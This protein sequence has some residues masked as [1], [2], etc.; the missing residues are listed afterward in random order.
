MKAY[1][2]AILLAI[3]SSYSPVAMQLCRAGIGMTLPQSGE[4]KESCGAP[5][6]SDLPGLIARR[7]RAPHIHLDLLGFK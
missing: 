5:R 4:R 1:S 2:T 3:L 6:A 7:H